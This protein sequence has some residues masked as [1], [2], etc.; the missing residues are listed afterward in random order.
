MKIP[1]TN[2]P[3]SDQTNKLF[4][5]S[6]KPI[7]EKIFS[8]QGLGE[9]RYIVSTEKN[10]EN[11]RHKY[12]SDDHSEHVINTS[13]N[14]SH[15]DHT[16]LGPCEK[17]LL[18][19]IVETT[20]HTI[21][22]TGA[23]GSGKSTVTNYV[24]DHIES[25]IDCNSCREFGKCQVRRPL[26]FRFDFLKLNTDFGGSREDRILDIFQEHLFIELTSRIYKLYSQP[27]VMQFF[28]TELANAVNAKSNPSWC[29]YFVDFYYNKIQI[30]NVRWDKKNAAEKTSRIIAWIKS[31]T[32]I[33]ENRITKIMQLFA[34]LRTGFPDELQGCYI[35]LFDNIDSFKPSVQVQIMTYLGSLADNS[36]VLVIVPMRLTTF[37]KLNNTLGARGYTTFQHAGPPPIQVIRHRL[38]HFKEQPEAY[39]LLSPEKS[40]ANALNAKIAYLTTLFYMSNYESLR[41]VKAFKAFAGNSIRRGLYLAERY[42][43]HYAYKYNDTR[44][45]ARH[46][47]WIRALIISTNPNLLMQ[48]DDKL[49]S[50]VFIDYHT[51]RN[52]LV[53]I[54][55]LNI[56]INYNYNLKK[57]TL[58][59]L[60][61]ELRLFYYYD[62]ETI[63]STIQYFN[64]FH[65]RLIFLLGNLDLSAAIVSNDR[66]KEIEI[67]IKGFFE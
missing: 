41:E 5:L 1:Y 57:V 67:E 22:I 55:V 38:K 40:Y 37:G 8:T 29:N 17:T 13:F 30:P 39:T 14:Y 9:I 2:I 27:N 18:N 52:S 11:N 47:W 58:F 23:L 65:K 66:M 20:F 10:I 43:L 31:E 46:D 16:R 53:G 3:D 6:V 35:F 42:L 26:I 24:L 54:R 49:I 4:N 56:L 64:D 7:I 62:D 15:I 36:G 33:V 34:C 44:S 32:R 21:V 12:I 28:E 19:L 51:R 48:I 25:T 45:L 61:T 59:D 50:N 63:L 60:V